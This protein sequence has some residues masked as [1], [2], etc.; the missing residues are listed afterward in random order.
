MYEIQKLVHGSGYVKFADGRE[1]AEIVSARL[2]ERAATG[3][4]F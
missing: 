2:K 1:K 4:L 3:F